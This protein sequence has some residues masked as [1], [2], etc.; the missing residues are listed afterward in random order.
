MNGGA[1]YG[2]KYKYRL[3]GP[4]A[5]LERLDNIITEQPLVDKS[6]VALALFASYQ[7]SFMFLFH[8][9]DSRDN[10][11]CVMVDGRDNGVRSIT[12]G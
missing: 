5:Y 1:G 9:R 8:V 2:W 12:Q 10:L 3:Y 4:N 7:P 6:T 11:Y